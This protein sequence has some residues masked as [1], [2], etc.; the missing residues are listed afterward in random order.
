[1]KRKNQPTALQAEILEA[2][3]QL[4][5]GGRIVYDTD[6]KY[7]LYRCDHR[8]FPNI[9]PKLSTIDSMLYKG[10]LVESRNEKPPVWVYRITNS[11]RAVVKDRG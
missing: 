3:V 9:R 7:K 5:P 4:G 2:L 1:M 10:W 6:W 8:E 11:G